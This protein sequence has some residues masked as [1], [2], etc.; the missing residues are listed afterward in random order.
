[1]EPHANTFLA[2]AQEECVTTTSADGTR[3]KTQSKARQEGKTYKTGQDLITS[4]KVLV[5]IKV[6]D[7]AEVASDFGG[8]E[9]QPSRIVA[10]KHGRTNSAPSRTTTVQR[11]APPQ[12]SAS[13]TRHLTVT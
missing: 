2:S 6:V 5:V 4:I 9:A 3:H 8:H 11:H 12:Y 13:S 10:A 1:M 7:T